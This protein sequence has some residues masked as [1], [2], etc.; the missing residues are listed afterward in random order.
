MIL[1]FLVFFIQ[2]YGLH[3][4]D[5]C[6]Q[7][8]SLWRYNSRLVPNSVQLLP[9]QIMGTGEICSLKFHILMC[10]QIWF[11]PFV[12]RYY[13]SFCTELYI[14]DHFPFQTIQQVLTILQNCSW[15]CWFITSV[16]FYLSLNVICPNWW[17][18]FDK[19]ITILWRRKQK[20]SNGN[21]GQK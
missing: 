12:H 17:L 21:F 10:S 6:C 7:A 18:K 19:V 3:L 20:K 9:F 15:I 14:I 13:D 8:W 11:L 2:T 5:V 1:N 4:P 16:G